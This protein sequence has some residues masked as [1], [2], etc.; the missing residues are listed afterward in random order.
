MVAGACRKRV[1]ERLEGYAVDGV[2]MATEGLSALPTVAN[3]HRTIQSVVRTQIR[4]Q[5]KLIVR[6]VR[7]FGR[8]TDVR[9][10]PCWR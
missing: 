4:G 7:T 6:G 10:D 3:A 8:Q 2:G 1:R 5:K 9:C